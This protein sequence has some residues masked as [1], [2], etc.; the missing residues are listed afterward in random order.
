MGTKGIFVTC[1]E[2]VGVPQLDLACSNLLGPALAGYF[3]PRTTTFPSPA[4]PCW[5]RFK[6]RELRY[7]H[8]CMHCMYVRMRFWHVCM[9]V[10]NTHT[11]G[12][13]RIHSM[14]CRSSGNGACSSA[15][16]ATD[17]LEDWLPGD[18]F[19]RS[20]PS[21][22]RHGDRTSKLNIRPQRQK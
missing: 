6:C 16:V 9:H 5:P 4:C 18:W 11:A 22:C 7:L 20:K 3:L 17:Y 21:R 14:H 8:A 10:P 12:E 13:A 1:A 19:Q 15:T 2:S